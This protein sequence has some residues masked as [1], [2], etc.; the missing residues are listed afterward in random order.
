[1]SMLSSR[2]DKYSPLVSLLSVAP[3]HCVFVL[4]SGPLYI[5]KH[6]IITTRPPMSK[7]GGFL[8]QESSSFS[9]SPFVASSNVTT[10]LP[11]SRSIP[12]KPGS[13][14]ESSFI[15]YVDQKLL[16]ISR[17]YEKRFNVGFKDET[18][19]TIEDLGYESFDQIARDLENVVD[20]VWVSGTRMLR[21]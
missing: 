7:D 5:F 6:S 21:Q 4:T 20:V 10:H 11:R 1:M 19:L 16:E 3:L 14:K 13:S 8:P 2:A 15:L 9:S 12:L 17:R 18:A